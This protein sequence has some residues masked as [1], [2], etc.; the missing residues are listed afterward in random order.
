MTEMA[1]ALSKEMGKNEKLQKQLDKKDKQIEV[2]EN[3]LA[4]VSYQL[5]GR[6]VELKELQ[7]ENQHLK[8]VHESDCN[9][10]KLIADKGSKLEK[11]NKELEEENTRLE[12]EREDFLA[13]WYCDH[14]GGCKVE[15]LEKQ[16][17]KM[18][19]CINDLV[20]LGEFNEN[21][22]EEYVNYQ[23]HEALKNAEQFVKE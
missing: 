10:L 1:K 6:E 3:K 8:E 15:E 16:I 9:S 22:D 18:K 23:V 14:I 21:T 2:L 19:C 17:E 20:H 11:W 5:E 12:G 13:N 7:E 4:N